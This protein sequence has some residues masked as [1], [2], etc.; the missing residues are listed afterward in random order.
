M[1]S[2]SR[3]WVTWFTMPPARVHVKELPSFYFEMA[4]EVNATAL[5]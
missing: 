3:L 2:R 1:L 4:G 5:T